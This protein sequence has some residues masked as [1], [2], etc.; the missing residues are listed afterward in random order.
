VPHN[1]EI[2]AENPA[3]FACTD[4]AQASRP[5]ITGT[6]ELSND[7]YQPLDPDQLLESLGRQ[8]TLAQ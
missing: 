7:L 2:Q 6:L 3:R 8:I 4:D 1:P 5:P